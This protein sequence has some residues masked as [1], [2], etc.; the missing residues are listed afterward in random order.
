MDAVVKNVFEDFV[1]LCLKLSDAT[2]N[3]VN[4][5]GK[6]AEWMDLFARQM[7]SNEIL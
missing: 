2:G 6:R 3:N 4:K 1:E 5:S 7:P